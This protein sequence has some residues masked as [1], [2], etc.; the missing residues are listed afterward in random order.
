MGLLEKC[1]SDAMRYRAASARSGLD[2]T[3]DEVQM[4]IG[5]RLAIRVPST[6]KSALTMGGEDAAF[7]PDPARISLEL[8]RS[9]IAELRCVISVASDALAVHDHPCAS[10]VTESSF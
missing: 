2:T 7:G 8:G 3:S 9:V 1:G 10:G 6:S 4:K 5:H